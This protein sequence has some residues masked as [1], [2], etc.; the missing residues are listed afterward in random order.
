MFVDPELGCMAL[1]AQECG[2]GF[3]YLHLISDNVAAKYSQDLSNE[4]ESGVLVGRDILY[5][6]VNRVLGEYL[7]SQV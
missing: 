2:V 5:A 7:R 6:E 3:G 1:A 4:R